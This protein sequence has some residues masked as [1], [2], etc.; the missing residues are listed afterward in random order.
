MAE[1]NIEMTQLVDKEANF[2][3]GKNVTSDKNKEVTFSGTGSI[4]RVSSKE[5]TPGPSSSKE[6]MLLGT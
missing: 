4:P 5:S 1:Y 3:D 2:Q 6:G